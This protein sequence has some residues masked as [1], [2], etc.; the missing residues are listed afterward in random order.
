MAEVAG[1]LNVIAAT[2]RR[3]AAVIW[4]GKWE[5]TRRMMSWLLAKSPA[6]GMAPMVIG[7]SPTSCYTPDSTS[8]ADP[9]KHRVHHAG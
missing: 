8:T 9:S 1:S 3:R 6:T 7:E 4:L 5:V 2:R